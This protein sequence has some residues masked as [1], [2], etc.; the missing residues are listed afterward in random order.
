MPGKTGKV[1]IMTIKEM[2]EKYAGQYVDVEVYEFTSKRKSVHT[3]FV[4]SVDDYTDETK[5]DDFYSELMDEDR[6][7]ESICAN[8]GEADFSEWYDDSDAKIL[9]IVL[10]ET[11]DE[12]INRLA[13]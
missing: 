1:E 10:E 4:A 11:K 3:D 5:V 12:R 2:K 13:E 7:N 9:V 8:C 6:Y